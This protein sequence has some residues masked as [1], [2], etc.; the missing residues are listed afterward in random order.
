MPKLDWETWISDNEVDLRTDAHHGPGVVRVEWQSNRY[1]SLGF[2]GL[3][4]STRELRRVRNW[5]AEFWVAIED[6]DGELHLCSIL[7]EAVDHEVG[8]TRAAIDTAIGASTVLNKPTLHYYLAD[9]GSKRRARLKDLRTKKRKM[10]LK[11]A[12]RPSPNPGQA[13]AK[14]QQ[15]DAGKLRANHSRHAE[16]SRLKSSG[17]T[18]ALRAG[19]T[20][21]ARR[22]FGQFVKVTF[23]PATKRELARLRVRPL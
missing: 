20:S 15:N 12:K 18:P 11:A 9:D 1:R 21:M 10:K 6:A 23:R 7:R 8:R 14:L 3:D 19:E 5:Q 2:A 13:M 17:G 16:P 22:S 4:I